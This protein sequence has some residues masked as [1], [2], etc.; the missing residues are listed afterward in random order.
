MSHSHLECHFVSYN[1]APPLALS[2]T[3]LQGSSL[4]VVR[5]REKST[6][7]LEE[8][9]YDFCPLIH[10]NINGSW[11]LSKKERGIKLKGQKN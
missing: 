11:S 8:S 5:A 4:N 3:R 10:C 1:V 2:L 9:A 7:G 6:V